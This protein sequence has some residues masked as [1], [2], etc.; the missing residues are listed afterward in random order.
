MLDLVRDKLSKTTVEHLYDVLSLTGLTVYQKKHM[1]QIVLR[2]GRRFS[3]TI[4]EHSIMKKQHANLAP[5]EREAPGNEG[6]VFNPAIRKMDDAYMEVRQ[7]A[8]FCIGCKESATI[9][10]LEKRIAELGTKLRDALVGLVPFD[11]AGREGK[12]SEN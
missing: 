9:L 2:R 7:K 12:R 4:R 5:D 6:V 1:V 3:T 10:D 11:L 8:V